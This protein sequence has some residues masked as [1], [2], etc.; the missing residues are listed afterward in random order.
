MLEFPSYNSVRFLFLFLPENTQLFFKSI[1][2]HRRHCR[3]TFR[4]CPGSLANSLYLNFSRSWSYPDCQSFVWLRF[5]DVLFTCSQSVALLATVFRSADSG[6]LIT[7]Y[8][9]TVRFSV[10]LRRLF[11][12]FGIPVTITVY[13]CTLIFLKNRSD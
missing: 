2:S 3:L 4:E 8:V 5:L 12:F 9:Q 10:P 11:F 13:M 7:Q 1:R 6:L